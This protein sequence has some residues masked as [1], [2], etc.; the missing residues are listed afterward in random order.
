MVHT[1]INIWSIRNTQ[2]LGTVIA[3][4]LLISP[5]KGE[6]AGVS[7]R[8]GIYFFAVSTC[9]LCCYQNIVHRSMLGR[10]RDPG[11]TIWNCHSRSV[12]FYFKKL[13][14]YMVQLNTFNSVLI[15]KVYQPLTFFP[16]MF[17]HVLRN[18]SIIWFSLIHLILKVYQPLTSFQHLFLKD[19]IQSM[20]VLI[21]LVK[22]LPV[23]Q[24]TR[25]ACRLHTRHCAG[26]RGCKTRTVP[27]PC[28]VCSLHLSAC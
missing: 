26:H 10:L 20:R 16:F 18:Y 7:R 28:A 3:G 1:V 27:H 4:I 6:V 24:P 2:G 11:R 19:L 5:L 21:T 12:M 22:G 25:I 23:T 14:L 15:L 13:Q 9:V 17:N 8:F